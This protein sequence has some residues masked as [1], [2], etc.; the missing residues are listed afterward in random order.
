MGSSAAVTSGIP[1]SSHTGT[2]RG[3][4]ST[5]AY[6]SAHSASPWASSITTTSR[7]RNTSEP[8]VCMK[9]A[10]VI[11]AIA[12]FDAIDRSEKYGHRWR[13]EQSKPACRAQGA[14]STGVS[15]SPFR[16]QV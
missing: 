15:V 5:V 16:M 14:R 7:F 13:T 3:A 12:R 11:A 10:S 9:Y 1:T 4:T 2:L 6:I 8:A